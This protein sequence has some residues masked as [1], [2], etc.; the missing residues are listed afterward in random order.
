MN[1]FAG[2]YV[3]AAGDIFLFKGGVTWTSSC[4]CMNIL[5]GGSASTPDYYGADLSWFAGTSFKRPI[6]DGQQHVLATAQ[7]IINISDVTN[8]IID[9]LEIRGLIV[10]TNNSFMLSSISSYNSENVTIRNCYVH[11]WSVTKAVTQDG[12]FGGV[13]FNNPMSTSPGRGNVI[14]SCI[15]S[16]SAMGGTC[17]F[18][19]RCVETI[20]NCIV[21]HVPNAILGSSRFVYGNTIHDVHGSFDP[22]EH[23]NGIYVFSWNNAAGPA[24]IH[25]N[26]IYN[27]DM[28][29]LYVSPGW[30]NGGTTGIAY[31]YNNLMY[32]NERGIEIDPEQSTAQTAIYANIFNNTIVG[33]IRITPRDG[34]P[35]IKKLV[36]VNNHY[37]YDL[38]S[39]QYNAAIYNSPPNG[40]AVDT[41]V[42]SN[43]LILATSMATYFG[44]TL[45]NRYA[46][47]SNQSPT[48]DK[49][50]SEASVFGTDFLNITRPQ[51]NAWDI[52]AYEFVYKPGAVVNPLQGNG[53]DVKKKSRSIIVDRAFPRLQGYQRIFTVGGARCSGTA[54]GSTIYFVED[55]RDGSLVR[56]MVVH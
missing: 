38:Q 44:Y 33:T 23:R 14:D 36:I 46:P 20:S 5:S 28:M 48:V 9:K 15:I 55:E 41:V 51:G 25:N 49:G 35:A 26:I 34:V 42:D 1:G 32:A 45:A 2:T 24:Y 3:H 27:V 52:G 6:F 56:A 10:N 29:P 22:T 47:T 19:I 54:P 16:D 13:I 40:G 50:V 11:D 12:M 18:G 37:I 4:F 43:N 7:K 31:I 21:H 8:I 17:G 30:N 39:G 53:I